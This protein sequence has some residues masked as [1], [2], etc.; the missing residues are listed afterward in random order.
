MAV[1]WPEKDR[2]MTRARALKHAIRT[3]AAKTGERYT[4]ARRHVLNDLTVLAPVDTPRAPEPEAP[5]RAKSKRDSP[6]SEA[7]FVEKTGHGFDHWFAVLDRFGGVQ[8][9]HTAAARHL[10]EA[11]GVDGWYAQGITVAYERA[12]GVRVAN[13]RC[14]GAFEVSVS[15]T[16]PADAKTII[17]TLTDRARRAKLH[18]SDK[19]LLP[20][21]AAGLTTPKSKGFVIR[22]DGLGRFRYN[23]DA[24]TVQFYLV[25]KPG[26]RVS[27]TVTNMKLTD[28]DMVES[29]RTVWREMLNSLAAAVSRE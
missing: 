11:H 3:R 23:W 15:K 14:D 20:S 22:P 4:T 18:V 25:P 28:S 26:N 13:Q 6:I 21:L 12:R 5:T 10:Y 2:L 29:R 17:R 19:T 8:K 27:V 7:K 16:I 9:G 1:V 24:T